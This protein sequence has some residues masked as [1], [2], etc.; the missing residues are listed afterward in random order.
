V[1]GDAPNL[2]L[3]SCTFNA[4][5]QAEANGSRLTGVES[6]QIAQRQ[7]KVRSNNAKDDICKSMQTTAVRGK[8]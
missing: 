3:R 1:E 6:E 5:E 7:K 2:E 4:S 8:V